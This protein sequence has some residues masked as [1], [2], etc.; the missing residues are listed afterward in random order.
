I[1]RFTF[2]ETGLM[3]FIF[4][5]SEVQR[6]QNSTFSFDTRTSWKKQSKN[7]THET[8]RNVILHNLDIWLKFG[9]YFVAF[10]MQ[11]RMIDMMEGTIV[12]KSHFLYSDHLDNLL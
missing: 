3:L 8:Q 5:Q 6:L 11:L 9:Q 10:L 1:L 12:R 7:A 2:N 4:F